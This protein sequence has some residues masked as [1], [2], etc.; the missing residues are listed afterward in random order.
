MIYQQMR[1]LFEDREVPAE[2][3]RSRNALLEQ[4]SHINTDRMKLKGENYTVIKRLP[5][6]NIILL[7]DGGYGLFAASLDDRYGEIEF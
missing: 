6:W 4:A 2:L 7:P 1:K 3:L 5:R